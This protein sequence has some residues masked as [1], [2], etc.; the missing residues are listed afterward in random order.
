MCIRA[1]GIEGYDEPG[2]AVIFVFTGSDHTPDGRKSHGLP[3]VAASRTSAEFTG[4]NA[5]YL[6]GTI[7][8]IRLINAQR[9]PSVYGWYAT[10]EVTDA[11]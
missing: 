8:N 4:L 6:A 1:Y 2:T 3:S 11:P 7:I 10:G 9:S 5:C